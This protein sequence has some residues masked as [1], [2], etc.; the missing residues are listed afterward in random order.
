MV[1]IISTTNEEI[2]RQL[3]GG[4][5][6]PSLILVEGEHGSGKSV[7]AAL[8]TYGMLAAGMRVLM[9][10]ENNIREYIDKMKAITYNFSIHFLKRR[11]IMLPLY[12]YGAKW[13]REH[14]KHLLPIISRYMSA[15]ADKF[16]AVVI[17]SIS[18]LTMYAEEEAIL[19]FIT[20]C[21]NLVT[22][23]ISILVTTHPSSIDENIG[24]KLR[25]A[26]DC[27]IRLKSVNVAGRDV[28]SVEIVKILG[29][30]GQVNSQ[31][32]A[33]VSSIFGLKIVPIA[34]A[35]A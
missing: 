26:S 28:K 30:M 15:N 12:V 14:A 11:L 5:P 24:S 16:D 17:D 1:R 8:F 35:N 29:S 9:I 13:S 7:V 19:D 4:L 18:L 20:R 33:E 31:F 27:Y 6:L 2:D 3:G 21:K 32:S 22:N 34:M 10:S 23:G 25:A